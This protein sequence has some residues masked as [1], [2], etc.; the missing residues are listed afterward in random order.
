MKR[1]LAAGLALVVAVG[2]AGCS[3]SSTGSNASGK[4]E[5]TVKV[6]VYGDNNEPWETA[7]DSLKEKENI[8]VELVKFSDYV[9]PNQA[10]SDGSVDLNSFQT[11]I[12]LDTYNNEHGTDLTSIG[13]TIIE[14]MGLYSHRVSSV[15]DLADGHDDG[16][17]GELLERA[18]AVGLAV[19]VELH[20]L[21]LDALGVHLVDGAQPVHL[22][23]L[24]LGLVE[25]LLVGGHLGLG[26]AV[27]DHRVLG[28]QTAG[29]AG[30]V[31]GGV[32]AAVDGDAAADDRL[33]AAGHVAQEVDGVDHV[34]GVDAGDLDAAR[35]MGA[36]GDEDGVEVALLLLGHEV[37]DR[38]VEDDLDAQLLDAG[39]LGVDDVARQA[40][41]GDAVAHH[42]AGLLA[43]VVDLDLVAETRQVV[44]GGQARGPGA[45]D[46][47]AV[48]G[49]VAGMVEP[50][51]V[52]DGHVAQVALDGVDRDGLV[53]VAA[54][55]GGLARVVA[56]AAVDGRERVVPHELAPG[57]LG[58]GLLDQAQ[59]LLAVLARGAGVVARR[60]QVD[61]DR[62]AR[63]DR[64]DAAGAGRKV[65][66]H[67]D[68]AM[69]SGHG[70]PFSSTSS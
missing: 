39:D 16:V 13:Y 40:V 56:D 42:A 35:Q 38:V 27:D 46:E 60:Q 6:G 10:L 15:G 4:D 33:V 36:D 23:A 7:A 34:P 55:A 53:E 18:G 61:I 66:Q 62:H 1:A 50:P 68:V 17:G 21:D 19:L 22:D 45:D 32:P 14:P 9:Q 29:G 70:E 43:G 28:A 47:D 24:A 2:L 67:G 64:P 44:G 31:H 69:F 3:G 5:V 20:D 37:G 41:L 58:I 26:A 52:R 12:Y 48:A 49:V 63:A 59:P 25:L 8:D 54:V 65:G 11:E 51:A 30:G 57:V